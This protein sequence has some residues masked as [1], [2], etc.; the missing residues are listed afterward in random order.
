MQELDATVRS[1]V[2]KRFGMKKKDKFSQATARAEDKGEKV[3][4]N[5]KELYMIHNLRRKIFQTRPNPAFHL[6]S[7]RK[8]M[9]T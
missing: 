6:N 8:N 2:K 5:F 4:V 3:N 7:F 9:Q 1:M